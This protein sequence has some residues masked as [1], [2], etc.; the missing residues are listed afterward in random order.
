[1]AKSHSQQTISLDFWLLKL[2]EGCHLCC[3]FAIQ[4]LHTEDSGYDSHTATGLNTIT[5]ET[6]V[7]L[8]KE[9]KENIKD[10]S[11]LGY[12]NVLIS[13]KLLKFHCSIYLFIKFNHQAIHIR[14][15]KTCWI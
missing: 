15:K 7:A 14:L 8:Q 11:L 3:P 2:H 10:T 4:H 6:S 9:H 12:D 1:M 5:A 13:N